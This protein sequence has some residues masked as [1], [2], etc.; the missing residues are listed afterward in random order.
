MAGNWFFSVQSSSDGGQGTFSGTIIQNGPNISASWNTPGNSCAKTVALEGTLNANS[1]TA[2][3]NGN[4]QIVSVTGTISTDGN[5]ASGSYSVPGGCANADTGTWSGTRSG[6]GSAA[7]TNIAGNWSFLSTSSKVVGQVSFTGTVVQTGSGISGAFDISGTP[8]AQ[9]GSL[10]G[11]L[12]ANSITASLNENGQTIS[13]SGTAS[14]DGNSASG[15][16]SASLGGCTNGDAGTWS[17][18]RSTTGSGTGNNPNGTPAG[19]YSIT[20]TATSGTV[21]HTTTVTLTVM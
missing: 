4:G 11:T 7:P 15:S 6:N 18:T 14:S 13:L 17:G 19:T 9:T 21:I 1:I 8:C 16:Y 5:S 3:L 2:S 10:A 12:N 20:V